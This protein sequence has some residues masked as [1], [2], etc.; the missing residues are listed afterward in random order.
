M[1]LSTIAAVFA[2]I[3]AF[4]TIAPSVAQAAH[5]RHPHR[6]VTR[7]MDRGART[8]DAAVERLNQSVLDQVRGR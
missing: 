3:L 6:H 7:S 4:G 5:A 8:G 1:K 2:A